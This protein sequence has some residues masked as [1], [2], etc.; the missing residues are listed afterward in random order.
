MTRM[1]RHHHLQRLPGTQR[2]LFSY[3]IGDALLDVTDS[4]SKH[5]VRPLLMV[6]KMSLSWTRPEP[7][8]LQTAM[9]DGDS[10]GFTPCAAAATGNLDT[11]R[12]CWQRTRTTAVAEKGIGVL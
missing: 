11:A 6:A 5:T 1:L 9:L 7:T 3:L 4:F 2:S 8:R 12:C 10:S